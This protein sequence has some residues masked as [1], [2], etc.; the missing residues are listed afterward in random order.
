M[1]TKEINQY[2]DATTSRE[3]RADMA[4]AVSLLPKS[5]YLSFYLCQKENFWLASN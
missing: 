5:G 4:F 2:Y 1:A 3:A